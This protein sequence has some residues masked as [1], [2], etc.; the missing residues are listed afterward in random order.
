MRNSHFDW[1]LLF[2]PLYRISSSLL[3]G[4]NRVLGIID[5][6]SIEKTY[7]RKMEGISRVKKKDGSGTTNGYMNIS[8]LLS[9]SNKVDLGYFKLFSHQCELMSQNKEIELAISE[10]SKLLPEDTKIIW[11]WDRGFDDRKNYRK[12]LGL[13]DE[14]VGR[15]Y[16][17]RLVFIKGKEYKLLTKGGIYQ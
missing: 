7:A 4:E 6:S 13:E 17:D 14:F 11:V 9:W 3:N 1:Q 15:A 5:L 16:H 8:I 10:V 12:V 2:N